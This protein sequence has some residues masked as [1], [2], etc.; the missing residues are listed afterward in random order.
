MIGAF[1]L[2]FTIYN[3]YH[4]EPSSF[5]RKLVIEGAAQV[6]RIFDYPLQMAKEAW[7]KYIFLVGVTE[8]N[9]KLKKDIDE[10]VNRIASYREA[11]EENKRLRR[12]LK[13]EEELPFKHVA[14]RVIGVDRKSLNKAMIINRGSVHGIKENAPVITDRGLVGRVIET[15]WHVSRVLLLIDETS[16]IDAILQTTRVQGIVQGT[17]HGCS[18]KYI[19]KTDEVKVGDA[20][21]TAGISKT[22]PKGLLIGYVSRVDWREGGMFKKVEVD[23]SV[24]FSRL[25]EVMVL[26]GQEGKP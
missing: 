6:R 5:A 4:E 8:E 22:F 3:I 23:P 1:F 7:K 14:A 24:D 9:R 13:L 12:L 21:I 18:I 19:G 16:N 11:Y 2:F 20:V 15:S 26:L 17:G 10:L 25:E